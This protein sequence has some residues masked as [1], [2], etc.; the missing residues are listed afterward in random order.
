MSTSWDDA[1]AIKTMESC[2]SKNTN[3]YALLIFF[4]AVTGKWANEGFYFEVGYITISG[5]RNN[6][7]KITKSI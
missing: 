6:F 1:I 5:W 7:K 3:Y 2:K 4:F